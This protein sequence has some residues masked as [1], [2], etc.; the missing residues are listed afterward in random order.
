MFQEVSGLERSGETQAPQVESKTHRPGFSTKM[1]DL[2]AIEGEK[3]G[4]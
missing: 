2:G 3:E 1:L 4:M